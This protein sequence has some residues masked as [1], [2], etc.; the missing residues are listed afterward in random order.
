MTISDIQEIF[1]PIIGQIVWGVEQGYGSFL[2]LEFGNPKIELSQVQKPK[3]EKKFPYNSFESRLV[4]VK[5]EQSFFVYM[6]NWKIYANNKELAYDESLRDD[7]E[8]ALMFIN[9][10]KLQTIQIDSTNNT[11]ELRFDLGGIIRITNET[12]NDEV[13]EMWNFY[14]ESDKVLTYRNDRKFSFEKADIDYG[15]QKFS[16]IKGK[17]T[18]P[19]IT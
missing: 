10:Q 13:N 12:Y 11:T 4:S 18:C 19:N 9:G 7:I 2:N 3:K 8:F 15:T 16:E 6:S 14:T 17:I 5:G 1:K